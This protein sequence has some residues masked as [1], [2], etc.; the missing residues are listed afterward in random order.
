MPFAQSGTTAVARPYTLI[1]MQ[2]DAAQYPA[3]KNGMKLPRI[4]R[5]PASG[6]AVVLRALFRRTIKSQPKDWAFDQEIGAKSV[7]SLVPNLSVTGRTSSFLLYACSFFY[8]GA[9][10]GCRSTEAILPHSP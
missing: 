1:A 9:G 5:Y 7:S 4:R 3:A 8:A 10:D 2:P 6:C